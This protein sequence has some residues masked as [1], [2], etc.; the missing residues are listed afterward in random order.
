MK[1]R[2]AEQD[3]GVKKSKFVSS[4]LL[5][6]G[7]KVCVGLDEVGLASSVS[8]ACVAAVILPYDFV[9]PNG[10]VIRDSKMLNHK[11]KDLAFD[12]IKKHALAYSVQWVTKETIDE[13]NV[14]NGK[15]SFTL[16]T[17]TC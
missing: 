16:Y 9:V 5:R 4:A 15:V 7:G 14:F 1:R 17:F 11:Q 2:N 6:V 12:Y 13:F 10:L 8:S 3:N